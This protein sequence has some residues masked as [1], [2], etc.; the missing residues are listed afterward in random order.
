MNAGLQEMV[1]ELREREEKASGSADT[2]LFQ[3]AVRTTPRRWTAQEPTKAEPGNLMEKGEPRKRPR[4][5]A[6]DRG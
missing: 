1:N 3:D 2:P 6:Q 4:P 5:P